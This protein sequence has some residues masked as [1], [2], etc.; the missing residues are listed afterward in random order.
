MDP[1]ANGYQIVPFGYQI[2]NLLCF[3]P[4]NSFCV[5]SLSR[6]LRVKVREPGEDGVQEQEGLAHEGKGVEEEDGAMEV[7]PKADELAEEADRVRANLLPRANGE[8]DV[9]PGGILA[10]VVKGPDARELPD[11][12]DNG[13]HFGRGKGK[14]KRKEE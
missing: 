8:G 6:A 3:Y 12:L 4:E 10:D 7:W 1:E 5:I 9:G 14:E 11:V 13:C 2:Q